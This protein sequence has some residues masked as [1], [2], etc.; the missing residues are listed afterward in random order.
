MMDL[1]DVSPDRGG[2]NVMD[3]H[4]DPRRSVMSRRSAVTFILGLLT[5]GGIVTAITVTLSG[6]PAVSSATSSTSTTLMTGAVP[7]A[8]QA[9]A[10]AEQGTNVTDVTSSAAKLMTYQDISSA[11]LSPGSSFPG[12]HESASA[13]VWAVAITGNVDPP[14]GGL[15]AT[16]DNWEVVVV[17]EQSGK[18]PLTQEGPNSLPAYWATLPDLSSSTS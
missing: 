7:S 1:D 13:T 8:Q 3:N 10:A 18:V 2:K 17:D 15:E 11:L 6:S 9:I 12:D 4:V 16:T 5:F 14:N